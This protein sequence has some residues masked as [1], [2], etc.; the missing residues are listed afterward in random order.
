MSRSAIVDG[1]PLQRQP[2]RQLLRGFDFL[3][4]A[5]A[6]ASRA[7]QASAVATPAAASD[8]G[9]AIAIDDRSITMAISPTTSLRSGSA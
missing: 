2:R 4:L 6:F 7:G 5:S 3:S 8:N 9:I 1:S